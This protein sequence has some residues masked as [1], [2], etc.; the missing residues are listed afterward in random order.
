MAASAFFEH[1][2]RDVAD[3]SV[4]CTAGSAA[5]VVRLTPGLEDRA[6]CEH[7]WLDVAPTLDGRP[8]KVL[9]LSAPPASAGWALPEPGESLDVEESKAVVE[10]LGRIAAQLQPALRV[11]EEIDGSALSIAPPVRLAPV[12]GGAPDSAGFPLLWRRVRLSESIVI[13]RCGLS[14][15]MRR[16]IQLG[17]D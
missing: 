4:S 9:A 3:G 7:L 17:D 16:W 6:L 1:L 14:R 8:P 11:L 10:V 12:R 5:G 13:R 2:L 15:S